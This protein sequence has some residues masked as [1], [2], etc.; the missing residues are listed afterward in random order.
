MLATKFFSSQLTTEMI[1]STTTPFVADEEEEEDDEEE[2]EE[3][4]GVVEQ[5]E[6]L[7]ADLW[8]FPGVGEE[9]GD[10]EDRADPEEVRRAEE[11]VVPGVLRRRLPGEL[12][13]EAEEAA[14]TRG[15][16]ERG[17]GESLVLRW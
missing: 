3:R 8:S 12:V 2:A 5:A 17:A 4:G 16:E 15:E 13:V 6:T 1:G 11:E 9:E 7:E 10:E 14:G